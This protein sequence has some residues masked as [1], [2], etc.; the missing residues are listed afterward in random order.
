M[1][2]LFP[3]AH[4]EEGP[5]SFSMVYS[6]DTCNVCYE[7]QYVVC[8][9]QEPAGFFYSTPIS[10]LPNV[11]MCLQNLAVIHKCYASWMMICSLNLNLLKQVVFY[12]AY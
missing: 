8:R 11:A 5:D 10:L 4:W 3:V 1:D 2:G 9:L 6:R 7:E 12:N